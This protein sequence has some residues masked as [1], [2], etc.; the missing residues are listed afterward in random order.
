[1]AASAGFIGILGCLDRRRRAGGALDRSSSG[2]IATG[3]R[4]DDTARR[5]GINPD[6]VDVTAREAAYRAPRE[7]FKD[8][9]IFAGSNAPG[10]CFRIGVF[11]AAV[12]VPPD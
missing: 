3:G 11:W 5:L 1:M 6:A 7:D 2:L 10:R 8:G 4:F 12:R 9:F